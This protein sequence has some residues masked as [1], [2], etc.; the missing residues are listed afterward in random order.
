MKKLK[1]ILRQFTFIQV[2]ILFWITG[3]GQGTYTGEISSNKIYLGIRISPVQ[4]TI[5]NHTGSS[6][7]QT[8][9]T[10]NNTISGLLE[11]GYLLSKNFGFSTGIGYNSF[12]TDISL[13]SY[14]TTI[15]TVDSENEAYIRNITGSNISENQKISMINIPLLANF[16]IPLS[17]SFGLSVQTGLGLSIPLMNNYSSTGTFT[18]SGYYPA[19]KV[20]IEDV[21]FEGFQS[22][23]NNADEGDLVLK[24][25]YPDLIFS[26]GVYYLLKDKLHLSLGFY[27][28]R[29]LSDLS[30]YSETDE[31]VLSTKPDEINSLMGS[32]NKVT[33]KSIGIGF[34]VRY[35]I[36]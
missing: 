34:G 25:L 15:N 1:Y 10:K 26:G 22:N 29:I 18:Y 35:F 7:D 23:V 19:Y 13:S 32:G 17:Q 5:T 33:A 21:P 11:A 14:S 9:S 28:D 30:G 12:L 36:K 20:T 4:T 16:L 24:S 27:Y 8:S 6:A 2:F 31:F 3:F